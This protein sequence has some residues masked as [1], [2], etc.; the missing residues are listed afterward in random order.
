MKPQVKRDEKLLLKALVKYAPCRVLVD[1]ESRIPKGKIAIYDSKTYT[2]YAESGH[3]EEE[4]FRAISREIA[5]D[6]IS[7]EVKDQDIYNLRAVCVSY[8]LCRRNHIVPQTSSFVKLP[9]SFTKLEEKDIRKEL[10]LIRNIANQITLDMNR[11][12][13]KQKDNMSRDEAR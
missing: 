4:L 6:Y 11:V 12:F 10:A 8:I 13:E 3:S 7:H 5:F 2:V 9:D 1:E